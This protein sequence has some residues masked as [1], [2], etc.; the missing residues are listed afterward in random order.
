MENSQQ[1]VLKALGEWM[2]ERFK[3]AYEPKAQVIATTSLEQITE[4]NPEIPEEERQEILNRYSPENMARAYEQ[5]FRQYEQTEETL[6][7]RAETPINPDAPPEIKQH[8]ESYTKNCRTLILWVDKTREIFEQNFPQKLTPQ[9]L[10]TAFLTAFPKPQDYAEFMDTRNHFFILH[11]RHQA[12]EDK[13]P[14]QAYLQ[15][16][17]IKEATKRMYQEVHT[18]MVE[19]LYQK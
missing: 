10:K 14:Q 15:N 19:D 6:R 4:I 8:I 3:K 16:Q 12:Q 7:K 5:G 2:G 1:A 17:A 11:L 13:I 9:N 18:K